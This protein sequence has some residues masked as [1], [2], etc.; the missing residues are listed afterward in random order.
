M[1]DLVALEFHECFG[2]GL[3]APGPIN[4]ADRA[5]PAG[6]EKEGQEHQAREEVIE[7]YHGDGEP[8]RMC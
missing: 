7:G 3:K 1:A 5:L 8:A 2:D 6:T 4:L